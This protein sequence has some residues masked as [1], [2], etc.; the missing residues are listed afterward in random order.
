M[1]EILYEQK[2]ENISS[3]MYKEILDVLNRQKNTLQN[4]ESIL[5]RIEGKTFG[6]RAN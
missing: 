1:G 3:Q 4:I 2:Q 6:E 5:Q